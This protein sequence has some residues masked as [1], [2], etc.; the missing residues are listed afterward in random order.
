MEHLVDEKGAP[1]VLFF[2]AS[3]VNHLKSAMSQV[4]PKAKVKK[5]LKNVR[6]VGVGGTTWELVEK[7]VKGEKLTDNQKHLGNQWSELLGSGFEPKYI[8][9]ICGSNTVDQFHNSITRD[10]YKSWPHSMF[11]RHAN[12]E[13]R[14]AYSKGI[15]DIDK[16]LLFF[17]GH[18]PASELLYSKILPRCWWSTHARRLARWLDHYIV[19]VLRKSHRIREIWVRDCFPGPYHFNENVEFGMLK[20]DMVHL[21][22]HG[23]R[24]LIK[25][26]MTPIL[27]KWKC[28]NM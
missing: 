22:Q 5:A 16:V 28:A 3:H 26:C 15:R 12:A 2:G 21:N 19:G 20:R 1:S 11:W 6:Y 8:V 13:L 24:A 25:G 23:N 14:K 4:D 17:K 7:H 18:F 9:L 27:H 10:I